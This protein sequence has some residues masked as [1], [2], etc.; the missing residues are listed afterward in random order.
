M[1]VNISPR[2]ASDLWGLGKH[3]L[4]WQRTTH[5]EFTDTANAWV[6]IPGNPFTNFKKAIM[7]ALHS[8]TILVKIITWKSTDS[9]LKSCL[10]MDNLNAI[11]MHILVLS[12]WGFLVCLSLYLSGKLWGKRE[13][14]GGGSGHWLEVGGGSG[15]CLSHLSTPSLTMASES[16]MDRTSVR[17]SLSSPLRMARYTGVVTLSSFPEAVDTASCKTNYAVNLGSIIKNLYQHYIIKV[18]SI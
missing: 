13:R 7:F 15:H 4:K 1:H 17:R 3:S 14:A 10:F 11:H 6:S 18:Y 8:L 9:F 5:K 12:N 16:C 2:A